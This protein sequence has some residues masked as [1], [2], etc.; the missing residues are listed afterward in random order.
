MNKFKLF[1]YLLICFIFT[2][3]GFAQSKT[4]GKIQQMS[5]KTLDLFMEDGQNSNDYV[6]ID[7]REK[8]EYD[9]GHIKYAIN[10]SVKELE[11]RLNEIKN[12]KDKNVVTTC[13][14]GKR[15]LAAAEILKKNG[16]K[17]IFNA[18]GFAQY[19]YTTVTK[20]ENIH[21]GALKKLLNNSNYVV[22]DTRSAKDYNEKHI[23]NALNIDLHSVD[24]IKT[25]DKN[26]TIIVYGY[27]KKDSF[28]VA[29]KINQAG[30]NV[31]NCIEGT[32]NSDILK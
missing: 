8:S 25:I 22:I 26:K 15:S 5:G 13:R 3:A 18:A 1:F 27:N 29:N 9:A 24:K 21:S 12:L 7:V 17:K 4:E 28:E 16:F 20:I 19:K 30:Y 32:G 10:I 6:F 2:A 14:S 31:I 23:G 11:T